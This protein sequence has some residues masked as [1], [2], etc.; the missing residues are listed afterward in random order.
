MKTETSFVIKGNICYST[1]TMKIC[2]A[3]NSYLVCENGICSG[4]YESLPTQYT[5]FPLTDYSDYVIIPGLSDLH[6]HAPQYSFTGLSMDKELLDW[7]N[8]YIF[9]EE[10]KY[11]DENYAREAYDEFVKEVKYGATTRAC[12]FATIHQKSTC[13]LMDAL[14]RAG[15]AG[16][17]GKVNMDRNSPKEL[18]EDTNMSLQDTYHWIEESLTHYQNIKPIITPRF[19]PSCSDELLQKLAQLAI[20][21]S[22]PIQSHLSENPEEIKWVKELVPDAN[23][24]A[25]S[26]AKFGLLQPS[27]KTVMA[28]CVYSD[29]EE[30]H[31]LKA[32]NTFV[33]HCPQSNTNLSSGIAPIRRFL[34]QKL[35]VGLGSDI[36]G[37]HDSSILRAMADSIQVSKLRWRL[38]DNKLKPLTVEE[39]FF[40]GTRGGGAFFGKVGSFEKGFLFDAVVLDDHKL[41]SVRPYSLAERLEKIIYLSE[42]CNIVRKYINGKAVF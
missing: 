36:A 21:Y 20:Q 1:D 32:S 37:G 28:H 19:V 29:E 24:Y 2:Y 30:I 4:V 11:K 38:V 42:R 15:L 25:A 5:A 35:N 9:P 12:V 13:Y 6:L 7:L 40:L 34:D 41:A 3:P 31:L 39:A 14:E 18:C 26:Y 10:S 16:Y 17:V 33:A 22:L 27:L 8:L 23:G